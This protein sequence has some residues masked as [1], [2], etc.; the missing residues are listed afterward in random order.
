MIILDT[1]VDSEI[2]RS[3]PDR[4]V[5]A[6]LETLTGDVAITAVTLAELLA[7]VSRL[8]DGGRKEALSARI[9]EAIEPFRGSRSILPFDDGAAA[10]YADVLRAREEVG[11]P[12]S[13]ADAQIAAI[14]L[15]NEATCATRNTRDFALTGVDLFDP[16]ASEL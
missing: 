14:C 6:W 5:L 16:W 7:G 12:I 15:A 9:E 2:L 8:P 1:N 13:T 3:A 11:R 4:R 10:F